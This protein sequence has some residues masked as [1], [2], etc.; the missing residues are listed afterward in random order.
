MNLLW[1]LSRCGLWNISAVYVMCYVGED[2]VSERFEKGRDFVR[3]MEKGSA[4]LG[5]Q[6][7]RWRGDDAN[8]VRGQSSGD[9]SR[10]HSLIILGNYG[11][12]SANKIGRYS[13]IGC[14]FS[15]LTRKAIHVSIFCIFF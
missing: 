5:V 15:I 4:G 1:L 6:D 14:E 8:I 12:G 3:I 10:P 7:A 2:N 9:Q 11:R 13:V